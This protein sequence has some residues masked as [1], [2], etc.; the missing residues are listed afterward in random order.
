MIVKEDQARLKA[1]LT[2]AVRVILKNGLRYN[3][4]ICI[5][6]LLGITLDSTDVFLININETVENEVA[7]VLPPTSQYS[8]NTLQNY[9]PKLFEHNTVANVLGLPFVE[10]LPS[11]N[12]NVAEQSVR[13]GANKRSVA[14]APRRRLSSPGG[15]SAQAPP[16]HPTE[17]APLQPSVHRPPLH[18]ME[19]SYEPHVKRPHH[20]YLYDNHVQVAPYR[21][22]SDSSNVNVISPDANTNQVC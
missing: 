14:G 4:E 10:G 11:L 1:L 13:V 20:D 12:I 22:D 15:N 17:R 7:H 9:L 3:Q 21:H 18:N 16:F 8:G 19:R 2:E 5:E 6:G